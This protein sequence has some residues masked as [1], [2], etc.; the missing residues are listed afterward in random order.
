MNE[1]VYVYMQ[2]G[3]TAVHHAVRSGRLSAL[4]V[5]LE[6]C[7]CQLDLKAEVSMCSSSAHNECQKCIHN[8]VAQCANACIMYSIYSHLETA[9]MRRLCIVLPL[10]CDGV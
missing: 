9:D 5:L 8:N 10:H 3:M 2:K 7:Q 6:D 1:C 4:K